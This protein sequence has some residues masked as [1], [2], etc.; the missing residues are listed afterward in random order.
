VFYYIEPE[1]AGGLG[2][3]SETRRGNRRLVVTRLNYTF[4][5]WLGDALIESTPCFIL[6]ERAVTP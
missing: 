5:G 3:K 2:P 6:T 4:D 1:V